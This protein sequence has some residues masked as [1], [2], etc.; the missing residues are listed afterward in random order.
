M[1]DLYIMRRIQIYLADSQA[2]ALAVRA[3]RLGRTKSDLIREAIDSYLA[4][5]ERST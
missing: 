4:P 5:D 2:R 1:Y 3:D